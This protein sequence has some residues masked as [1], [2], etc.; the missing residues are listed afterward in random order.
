MHPLAPETSALPVAASLCEALDSR[1]TAL[2]HCAQHA[3]HA[4]YPFSP[5]LR[6][7]NQRRAYNGN[8]NVSPISRNAM[9]SG[10]FPSAASK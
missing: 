10:V 3:R 7:G 4:S 8:T 5:R 9:R 2:A 1:G 6:R